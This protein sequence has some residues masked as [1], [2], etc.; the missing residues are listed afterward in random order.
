MTAK[1]FA[2]L[3]A[4]ATFSG[5][6]Y[7]ACCPAHE[8]TRPSLT[9]RDGADG[10]LVKCHR[11]CPI[12]A[13]CSALGLKLSDL[14]RST[15]GHR[16]SGLGPAVATYDYHDLDG[17][18]RYQVR[19]YANPKTFRQYRSIGGQEFVPGLGDTERV[20]YRLP[21]IQGQAEVLIVEGEKDVDRLWSLGLPATTNPMGAGKWTDAYTQQF[22]AA[23]IA[24]AIIIPDNDEPGQ[25][26]AEAVAHAIADYGP[27]VRLVPLPGLVPK[28]DVSDWLDAGHSAEDLQ[29]LIIAAP[30]FDPALSAPPELRS[31]PTSKK[32]RV[33]PLYDVADP[34]DF[35][36]VEM[37]ID[38]VLPLTGLVWVGGLPKRGK[39]LLLLY[40]VLCLACRRETF[41]LRFPI[42]RYPKVLSV[43]REDGGARLKQRRDDILTAW[44]GVSP[45][46]GLVLF[47]IRPHLDLLNAD[48]VAWLTA[49]CLEQGRRLLVLD[50]WT[51]LSPS[52]DPLGT[53][54]QTRLAQVVV[55]LAEAI[56]GLVI[57][58][59]H[60]RKNRPQGAPISS[61]DIFGP[62]QKWQSAEHLILLGDTDA[63]GRLE[64]FIEGKDV[65][66]ARFFLSVSRRASTDEKFRYGGT[67][68]DIA[69][70]QRAVGDANRA[71]VRRVVATSKAALSRKEIT[72]ALAAQG[73]T[74]GEDTIKKHLTA[75]VADRVLRMVGQGRATR[76][77]PCA[78][79]G[80]ESVDEPS[81]PI[82]T[83][84][85]ESL[86]VADT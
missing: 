78:V 7:S 25:L 19:R 29:A 76:Y 73:L 43:A 32:D 77:L 84:A 4:P 83:P 38:Q 56:G 48:D 15:N 40:L 9:F 6:E 20:L 10:L 45:E 55:R 85:Q 31:A 46:R 51:A 81:S 42:R 70:A 5:G 16:P 86:Y 44:E 24:R 75:L 1:D 49:T 72:T 14:F 22:M 79:S 36:P 65:E 18:V 37:L 8:D 39:S 47:V 66:A 54:D 82:R 3:V 30:R 33:W 57:V 68:Q 41:A 23:G 60:S 67:V 52:A 61:A 35:P 62:S 58:V 26:H 28:G 17:R 12:E 34:W 21:D 53:E 80:T 74:L 69:E 59:D 13:I 27:D 63:D 50:T 2:E 11:Q 64:V 71:A